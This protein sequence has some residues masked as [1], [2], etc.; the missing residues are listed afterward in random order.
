MSARLPATSEPVSAA[1]PSAR[2]PPRV[3]SS[4][5]SVA[6]SASARSDLARASEITVRSSSKKSCDGTEETP[7]VPMPTRRPAAR[8]S[9]SG[10]IPQPSS[11][12][13][14]GQWVTATPWPARRPISSRS[15][16]TQCAAATRSSSS[17]AAARLRIPLMPA[18]ST[19]ISANGCHGPSPR[20]SQSSSSWL[21]FRCVAT[22]RS[23]V[24]QA[25]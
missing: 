19:S 6:D 18:G 12:F 21:S 23:S 5:A 20:S 11:A 22:G 9:S 14:R 24:M 1:S 13:E 15:T 3:A 2:A 25:A 10:A 16:L 17:P 7:S 8:S 4:S